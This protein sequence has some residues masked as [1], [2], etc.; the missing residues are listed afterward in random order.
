MP[1]LQP[2]CLEHGAAAAGGHPGPKAVR[3]RTLSLV[4]LVGALHLSFL[5]SRL[6]VRGERRRQPGRGAHIL[7]CAPIR[8]GGEDRRPGC[9]RPASP[10][11]GPPTPRRVEPPRSLA[12]GRSVTAARQPS[13]ASLDRDV[14]RLVPPRRR[15]WVTPAAPGRPSGRPSRGSREPFEPLGGP[16]R[17]AA[18]GML[19]GCVTCARLDM[20]CRFWPPTAPGRRRRLW[21]ELL[22]TGALPCGGRRGR[23]RRTLGT[24]RR[25]P[26]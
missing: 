15:G 7:P 16:H 9:T 19:R 23:R 10:R 4:W 2:A 21:T 8:S 22:I 24:V 1:A 17:A 12:P 5:P 26:A 14:G 20:G 11:E 13:G 3:P 25:I 6:R 18:P